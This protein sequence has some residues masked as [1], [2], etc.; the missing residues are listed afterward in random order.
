MSFRAHVVVRVFVLVAV[1]FSGCVGSRRATTNRA[2]LQLATDPVTLTIVQRH[3]KGIPGSDGIV[4]VKIGDITGGQVLLEILG[5]DKHVIVDTVSVSPHDTVPFDV[6]GHRY[7][8]FVKKLHNFLTGD[9]FAVF[10][11]ST[12]LL[13]QSPEI[14]QLLKIIESSG[15]TFIRNGKEATSSEA[16]AHLRNKWRNASLKITTTEGFIERI[17]S[18][19]SV[20]SQRYQVKLVNGTVVDSGTWLRQQLRDVDQEKSP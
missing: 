18:R 19:S 20:T 16:A 3:S 15:V 4:V 5:A 6:D 2:T 14:E 1:C 7:Y 17:A 12:N 8:L 10:D 9:D 13:D 11:I